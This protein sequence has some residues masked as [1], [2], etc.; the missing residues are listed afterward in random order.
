MPDCQ[1]E[2][3]GSTPGA[4][5]LSRFAIRTAVRAAEDLAFQAREPGSTPGRYSNTACI[6]AEVP[7]GVARAA[8]P[9]S[10]RSS[11]WR[12]GGHGRAATLGPIPR[13]SSVPNSIPGCPSGNGA[14]LLSRKPLVRS[15]PLEPRARAELDRRRASYA[16]RCRFES[17]RA[18]GLPP[19]K[20]IGPRPPK[21]GLGVRI[22]PGDF[23][24][25]VMHP[26][27]QTACLA[28][29]GGSTPLRR[30]T[31]RRRSW[32]QMETRSH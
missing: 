15:Q 4:R 13:G 30:A 10:T 8:R 2:G 7:Q 26:V 22:A 18:H 17:C 9:L 21:A 14:C 12:S 19:A 32:R 1:S 6:G 25:C 5:S 29:E 28:A 24:S 3:P 23:R 20:W 11:T 27:S 31:R 16:R